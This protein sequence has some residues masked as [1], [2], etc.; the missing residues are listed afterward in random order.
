[1]SEVFYLTEEN[2][3]AGI[4]KDKI[5]VQV[6]ARVQAGALLPSPL[7]LPIFL[8]MSLPTK[9]IRSFQKILFYL[10]EFQRYMR[11]RIHLTGNKKVELY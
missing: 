6:F 10:K 2:S 4:E 8:P 9:V 11:V 5:M 3:Q 7:P 1:M